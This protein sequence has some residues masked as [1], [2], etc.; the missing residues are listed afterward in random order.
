MDAAGRIVLPKA[1]REQAGFR[2]GQV[3]QFSCEEGRVEI[4]PVAEEVDVVRTADGI[5]VLVPREPVPTLTS[6]E[7]RAVLEEVR[8]RHG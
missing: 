6:D 2:P 8:F 7:V 4:V 3:L 5:S 1:V